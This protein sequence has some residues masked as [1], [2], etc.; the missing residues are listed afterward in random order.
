M[1]THDPLTL[2]LAI[3]FLLLISALLSAAETAFTSCS[4]P[5]MLTLENEG[6]KRAALVNRIMKQPDLLIGAILVGYNVINIVSSALTT[7]AM[8]EAFGEAGL[9]Y[10]TAIMSVM[11]VLFV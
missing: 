6:S 8:I 5:R 11:I 3:G 10:A 7:A 2:T 4:K 9:A 1:M